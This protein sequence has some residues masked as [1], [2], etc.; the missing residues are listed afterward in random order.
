MRIGFSL[1]VNSK[2]EENMHNNGEMK[3]RNQ[4]GWLE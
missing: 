2:H 1:V 4:H 3:V